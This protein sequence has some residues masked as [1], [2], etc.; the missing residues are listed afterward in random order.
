MNI[1]V[2][3]NNLLPVVNLSSTI[4]RSCRKGKPQILIWN[5]ENAVS[6]IAS[7]DPVGKW[8]GPKDP[9]VSSE[10]ITNLTTNTTFTLT[11]YSMLSRDK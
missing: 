8:S 7:S 10:N 9:T 2:T 6:C 4:T 11:L 3:V 5:V 1:A